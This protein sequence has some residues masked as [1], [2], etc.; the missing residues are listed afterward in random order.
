MRL[1]DETIYMSFDEFCNICEQI[2]AMERKAESYCPTED[3]IIFRMLDNLDVYI[4]FLIW[5][6]ET[7]FTTPENEKDRKYLNKFLEEYLVITD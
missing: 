6:Q 7:G 4:E 2:D 3:D 1:M 5:V